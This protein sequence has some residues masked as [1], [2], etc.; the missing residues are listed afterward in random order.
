[1]SLENSLVLGRYRV[2]W[3][4]ESKK[5]TKTYIARDEHRDGLGAPVLVKHY[6]HDLGDKDSQPATALFAELS[7]LTHIRHP[8]VISLLDYGTVGQC[9]VTAH[10]HLP[11]MPLSQLCEVYSKNQDQFPPHLAV[12]IA[13]R[14][15]ETLHQ[16]HTR[17]GGGFVHGRLTLGCIYLPMSGEP[18]I[19]DFGLAALEDVAAEAEMQLGFFQTRMSYSAPELTRG[20]GA[21][22]QGDTYSVALLLYRLLTGSN[23]FRGRSI[24]ETLQRVLQ[25]SPAELMM[26]E[27]EGCE[28]IN[29]VFKRALDKSPSVRFQNCQELAQALGGI[30]ARSDESMR[31][32]LMALVRV[33]S[34]TDWSQLSRLTRSSTAASS[35]P[36]GVRDELRLLGLAPSKAPAFVSGLVT[37]QPISVEEHTQGVR[38]EATREKRDRRRQMMMVPTVLIPAAAIIFGLFLGRLGG[39][40]AAARAPQTPAAAVQTQPLVNALVEDLRNQLRHCADGSDEAVNAQQVELE[41]GS[42]GALTGVRLLPAELA[43]SRLGACLLET[44]WNANLRAPGPMSVKIPLALR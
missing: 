26:P 24:P 32:E 27:W 6:L 39:M 33:H 16:C 5:L 2:L 1:M 20:G 10:A 36:S 12:Y 11:G 25:L 3:T 38:R 19:S 40:S 29:A 18:N 9:L 21:T 15:L 13:R 35:A 7:R 23:P 28:R 30:Q 34:T 31:E 43:H 14:L 4:I 22:P 41:F 17:R 44:A 8:G 42:S 37:E